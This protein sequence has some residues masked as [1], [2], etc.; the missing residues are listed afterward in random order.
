MKETKRIEW[1]DVVKYVCII[2]VMLS[3]LETRT[4][5]WSAFYFPFFLTAFFFTAGYVYK[6]KADFKEFIYKKVRQLFVPWLVFSVFDIAL[7]QVITFNKHESFLVELKWNFLQIRGQGDQIWFVAALFVAFIPFYFFIQWYENK[8]LEM[9]GGYSRNCIIAV[10]LAWL[11]SFISILYNRLVPADIFP[12]NSNSL[13]WHV[14]YVFQAMFYMVLGYMFRHN[15]EIKFDK[16]NTKKTRTLFVIIYIILVFVPF[17]GRI[18]M[19]MLADIIYQYFKSILGIAALISIAK[20]IK[21]NKYINYVGQNTL[22]YFALHGKFLSIIQTLLKKFATNFYSAVL[23]NVAISSLFC[24]VFSL[25]L[26]VILI[27]PAYIINKWFPF[28]VGRKSIHTETKK[29]K[30]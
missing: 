25:V 23:N 13:P 12:W 9:N 20:V 10:L 1:V 7:S 27:I 18:N 8:S 29:F 26:S 22:I 24:L 21:A 4:K 30:G 16:C 28:I 11:L 19:H 2:M 15:F 3:H 5:I 17:F 6:A 14:E